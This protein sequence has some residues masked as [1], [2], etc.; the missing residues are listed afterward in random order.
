MQIK[1]TLR[2]HHT[3]VRMARIRTQVTADADEDVEKEKHIS[4]VGEI[5]GWY[6]H[7]G[8]HSGGFS[9]I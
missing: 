1:T 4:I 5:A 3:P 2:F 8:S 6:N 9:E 7:S